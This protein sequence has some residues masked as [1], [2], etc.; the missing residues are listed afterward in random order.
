MLPYYIHGMSNHDDNNIHIKPLMVAELV[1]ISITSYAFAGQDFSD[2]AE[3]IIISIQDLP[4][5]L[6]G[7]AYIL[8]LLYGT[9]GILKIKDHVENP[10]NAKLAEG[11]IRLASGGALFALPIVIEAMRNTIGIGVGVDQPQ[12]APILFN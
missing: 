6:T 11:A 8:G 3:N 1:L 7:I 9:M 5:L 12:L 2:I 4:K 10:S